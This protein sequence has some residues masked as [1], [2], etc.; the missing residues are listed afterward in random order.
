MSTVST[1]VK[2]E[3]RNKALDILVDGRALL[4][5]KGIW[6]KGDLV[7][8][9]QAEINA[10][11][12]EYEVLLEGTPHRVCAL[13]ALYAQPG[14]LYRRGK[15]GQIVASKALLFAESMLQDAVQPLKDECGDQYK[16][17]VV[18]INDAKD[19]KK[20]KIISLYDRAIEAVRATL[21]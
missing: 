20:V 4:L 21:G 14:A 2:R 12:T 13:G 18:D 5:Q 9:T 11:K 10:S 15:K 6:C 19:T 1:G 3:V 17:D 8:R 7:R 16:P